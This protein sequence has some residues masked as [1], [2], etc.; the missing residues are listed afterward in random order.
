MISRSVSSS[1]AR[2]PR[3]IRRTLV[4]I[5]LAC[6][7]PAW[8]GI[9]V[10]IFGMY[11]VLREFAIAQAAL[12]ALTASEVLAAGDFK[13]F[14][15]R[16][17]RVT[18]LYSFANIIVTRRTGQQVVNTVLPADAKLPINKTAAVDDIVFATRKPAV[19]DLFRGR[20]AKAPIVSVKVP[21]IY[22]GEVPRWHVAATMDDGPGDGPPLAA[23]AAPWRRQTINVRYFRMPIPF[24]SYV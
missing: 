24:A 10:L 2:P 1:S 21:V 11:K 7:L 13:A 18:R 22:A 4:R 16:A 12:E 14:R 17:L 20:S 9:A 5:V 6:V 8:L 19:S 23:A 15:E 3:S